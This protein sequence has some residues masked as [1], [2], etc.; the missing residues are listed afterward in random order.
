M[1]GLK[2]FTF[3]VLCYN[4]E[5]FIIEHLESIRYQIENYGKGYEIN[6]VISD[7]YSTDST[8]AVAKKWVS[9][10]RKLF[11]NVD[12]LV[13][14]KN[15]GIVKNEISLLKSIKTNNFKTLAGDDLYYK[16]NVIQ[17]NENCD[18]T[19]TKVAKFHNEKIVDYGE[20]RT[21]KQILQSSFPKKLVSERLKYSNCLEAPGVFYSK[22]LLTD[23]LF[24]ILQRYS[25]LEDVPMWNYMF[26]Q[27]NIRVNVSSEI[28]VIYRDDVG[29]SNNP[30]H[31]KRAGY[32]EDCKKIEAEIFVNNKFP[33]KQLFKWKNS[34]E[35]KIIAAYYERHSDK[36][37]DFKNNTEMLYA[38]G[39][40][41]LNEIYKRVE[42]FN[43][44]EGLE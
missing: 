8:V 26:N 41:Y 29:I 10:Y 11:K 32:L 34:I 15:R 7:D 28:Y 35:K 39:D 19:I 13:P 27:E 42:E 3:G 12:V 20:N 38:E 33:Q 25:W 43:A 16:N 31:S 2:E 4:Q 22:K 36:L 40:A 21:F 14:E 18:I 9:K 44:V 24:D 17:C 1:S 5:D 6:L 37:K 30:N 23:E